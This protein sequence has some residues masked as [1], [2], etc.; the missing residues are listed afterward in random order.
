MLTYAIDN[1][2]PATIV[3]ISGDRDFVY[4][5]SVLC[6]RRYRVVLVAPNSAHAS[7][8]SQASSVLDWETDIMR[9]TNPRTQTLDASHVA[10]DDALHRSPRRPM[11]SLGGPLPQPSPRSARRSSFRG[12]VF[13]PPGT[14]LDASGGSGAGSGIQGGRH[15]RNPSIVT[16]DETFLP[17]RAVSAHRR[18][19]S[20][21][22]ADVTTDVNEGA[23][24]DAVVGPAIPDIVEI[25]QDL[26]ESS[27]KTPPP[28]ERVRTS[29]LLVRYLSHS[30]VLAR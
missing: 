14:P 19:C 28:A 25:I 11:L 27:R 18:A 26:E 13:L 10:Q 7:L 3:L 20:A 5:V 1:P 4:A 23:V 24:E 16:T 29:H 30:R 12:G 21:G 6:L 9:R 17:E 8:K 22:V 15:V 2:A